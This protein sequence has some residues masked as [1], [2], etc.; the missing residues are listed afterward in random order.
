VYNTSQLQQII[1]V[2]QTKT[3]CSA[4]KK[5]QW[6]NYQAAIPSILAEKERDERGEGIQDESGI[7]FPDLEERLW[8]P[9]K[10]DLPETNNG[11]GDKVVEACNNRLSDSEIE[12]FLVIARS[13]GT[14]ARAL[15]CSS[16]VK[17]PRFQCSNQTVLSLSLTKRSN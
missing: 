14:F 8:V 16:S 5:V 10:A 15:D 3:K 9:S 13:V 6:T 2:A 11:H 17:Q 12:K 7:V 1:C 4:A